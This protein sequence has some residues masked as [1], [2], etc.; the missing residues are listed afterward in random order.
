[1]KVCF[2]QARLVYI[3]PV[4]YWSAKEVTMVDVPVVMVDDCGVGVLDW[5]TCLTWK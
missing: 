3:L 2:Y 4:D 5:M 1:V